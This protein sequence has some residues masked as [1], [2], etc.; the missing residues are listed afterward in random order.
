MFPW[1]CHHDSWPTISQHVFK[2]KIPDSDSGHST[3]HNLW[4]Q[5]RNAQ[6]RHLSGTKIPQ[7]PNPP[8]LQNP[9]VAFYS[10]RLIANKFGF[11]AVLYLLERRVRRRAVV[12]EFLDLKLDPDAQNNALKIITRWSGNVDDSAMEKAHNLRAEIFEK[13]T[14]GK[15][16][17]NGS[18]DTS[19]MDWSDWNWCVILQNH[20]SLSKKSRM[21]YPSLTKHSIHQT[22]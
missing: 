18:W 17:R 16:G 10:K 2:D 19:M 14:K 1:L 3:A 4:Q 6:I 8:N 13:S 11:L 20:I 5:G 22:R 12:A 7:I 15:F 21:F 9:T